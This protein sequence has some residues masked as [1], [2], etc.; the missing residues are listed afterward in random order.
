MMRIFIGDGRTDLIWFR[1][2]KPKVVLKNFAY[3]SGLYVEKH[4]RFVADLTGKKA[5]DIG[6]E[7]EG[8]CFAINNSD[9]TFHEVIISL[10][11]LSSSVTSRRVPWGFYK[12]FS[13]VLQFFQFTSS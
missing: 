8:V 2:R 10:P 9:G 13:F 6:F 11:L 7:K 1:L 12:T 4:P 3:S 5:G